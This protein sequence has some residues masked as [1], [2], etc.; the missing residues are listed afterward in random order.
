MRAGVLDIDDTEA[1]ALLFMDLT[2]TGVIRKLL[3]GITATPG[4]ADIEARVR[5]AVFVFMKVYGK[6]AA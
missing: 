6:P 1:A 5:R 3:F 4:E 2:Q